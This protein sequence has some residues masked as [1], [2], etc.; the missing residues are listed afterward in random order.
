MMPIKAKCGQCEALLNV[1]DKAAGRVV[2]CKSCGGKVRVPGTAAATTSSPRGPGR[3]RPAQA[4]DDVLRGLN[5]GRVEDTK[6]KVCP[7]C[8]SPVTPDDV[9]CPKCGVNIQTGSLSERQRLRIARKGPPPGEFYGEVWRNSWK[10]LMKHKGIAGLTM[11]VWTL[12]LSMSMTSLYS[13]QW[14]V[15]SRAKELMDSAKEAEEYIKISGDKLII[16]V[17]PNGEVHY[18]DFIYRTPGK[19][20]LPA[21]R[22]AAMRSP[23]SVFWMGMTIVFQLGFGGW[24][25]ML[26]IKIAELTLANQKK[27]KRFQIDFF[28][29]L[30]MGFRFYF[31]PLVVML[32]VVWIGPLLMLKGMM[33]AGAVVTGLTLC[34]PMLFFLPAAV[35]HTTQRY[36]Y[37]AW[38][39]NWMALDFF[40]TV[41]GTLYIAAMMFFLVLLAPG[42]VLVT[43]F[44][45][46]GRVEQMFAS[47]RLQVLDWFAKN[48]SDFGDGT[49]RYTFAEMPMIFLTFLVLFA[50]LNLL[51]AFP[52]VFMMRAI[53]LYGVYFKADL[54]IVGEFPDK[55]PAG[56]GPRM[57]AFLVDLII[58]AI[59]A[60]PA[61]LS[62]MVGGWMAGFYGLG[63]FSTQL[64]WVMR[65][66]VA[67]G[68]WSYYFAQGESGQTRSTLGKWSLGLIV[69]NEDD[70]PMNRATA[71]KRVAVSY[72]TVLTLFI[73]FI[74]VAFRKD[75]RALHDTLTKTKVLWRGEELT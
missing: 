11:L 66:V 74:M 39:I 26:A 22:V 30:T 17:E 69:L 34:I 16:T 47:G 32:P 8:A 52:A 36:G 49:A 58:L 29:N 53:G 48:I 18:D 50:T 10:F 54:S 5:L 21:P 62:G 1:P 42:A 3:G 9:E 70:R 15:E 60:V 27:I 28:A 24:A 65:I 35:I 64:S 41:G 68:I 51:M 67:M 12:M 56:F 59:L 37:R 61:Y 33:T 40:R 71:F 19:T 2:L 14:C 13:Q 4:S 45:M 46:R 72:L 6:R 43:L 25:W 57:L 7:G 23:P 38:L 31:W 44:L 63:E 55:T 20:I 73:G 75:H